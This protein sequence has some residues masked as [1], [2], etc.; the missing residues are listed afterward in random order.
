M[1]DKQNTTPKSAVAEMD[2]FHRFIQ[3]EDPQDIA[4]KDDI[5][6]YADDALRDLRVAT[7]HLVTDESGEKEKTGIIAKA[8]TLALIRRSNDNTAR[9]L[10]ALA[11]AAAQPDAAPR[12]GKPHPDVRGLSAEAR[13]HPHRYKL[14]IVVEKD[15]RQMLGYLEGITELVVASAGTDTKREHYGIHEQRAYWEAIKELATRQLEPATEPNQPDNYNSRDENDFHDMGKAASAAVNIAQARNDDGELI[16]LFRLKRQAAR[17][18]LAI[19][20]LGARHLV[21]ANILQ[22][23]YKSGALEYKPVKENPADGEAVYTLHS[24]IPPGDE[25]YEWDEQVN[26]FTPD[27]GIRKFRPELQE[28]GGFRPANASA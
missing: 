3:S 14:R 16:C 27:G 9:K 28:Y 25:G 22:A 21:A 15:G 2:K 19:L 13:A 23:A 8:A 7:L 6:E 24:T 17:E 4:I 10:A 20:H 11:V 1:N 26:L 18:Q 12:D 5:R